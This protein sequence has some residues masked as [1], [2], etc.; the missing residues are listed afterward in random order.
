[1]NIE[2]LAPFIIVNKNISPL[3]DAVW[4]PVGLPVGNDW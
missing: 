2:Q 1:M 3:K 4:L